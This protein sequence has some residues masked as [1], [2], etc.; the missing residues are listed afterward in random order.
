[1]TRRTVTISLDLSLDEDALRD[2]E[3]DFGAL[4]DSVA[5]HM[6][7]A[8]LGG[9]CPTL[10]PLAVAHVGRDGIDYLAGEQ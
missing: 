6:R 9:L 2:D 7:R 8:A 3:I 4:M 10:R 5:A 1:M